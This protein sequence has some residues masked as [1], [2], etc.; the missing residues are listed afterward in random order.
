MGV[1]KVIYDGKTLI[2]LTNDSIAPETLA[3]GETAHD[4]SGAM[5]VGTMAPINTTQQT[6]LFATASPLKIQQV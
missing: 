4:A 1:S 6:P 5:I 3:E 2:D